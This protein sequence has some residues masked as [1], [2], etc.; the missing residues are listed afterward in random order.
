MKKI[1]LLT[2]VALFSVGCTSSS[3]LETPN[4]PTETEMMKFDLTTI[5]ELKTLLDERVSQSESL[6]KY[7]SENNLFEE[8]VQ[9]PLRNS[10]QTVKDSNSVESQNKLSQIL[11]GSFEVLFRNDETQLNEMVGGY[12]TLIGTKESEIKAFLRKYNETATQKIG[13]LVGSD[14]I[15]K[16]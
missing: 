10:I 6:L 4:T 8:G 11:K 12:A 1:L 5:P 3:S 7:L 16:P 2:L 13:I 9:I 14:L 15:P